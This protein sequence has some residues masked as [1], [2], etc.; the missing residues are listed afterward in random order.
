MNSE[1]ISDF[2]KIVSADTGRRQIDPGGSGR[3]R[4]VPPTFVP[5]AGNRGM[6]RVR[7]I[8]VALFCTTAGVLSIALSMVPIDVL[9]RTRTPRVRS[10][11]AQLKPERMPSIE[12]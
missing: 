12:R 7:R 5:R 2:Q 11:R 6:T 4:E 8:A 9:A 10:P 1:N 3:G